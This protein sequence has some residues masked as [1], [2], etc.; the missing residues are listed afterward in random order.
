MKFAWFVADGAKCFSQIPFGHIERPTDGSEQVCGDW[1]CITGGDHGLTVSNDCKHSF[2]AKGNE[3]LLT[4]LRSALYADHFGKRDEFCEFMDQGEHTF[5]YRLAPFSGFANAERGAATLQ[6]PL[7]SYTETFHRGTLPLTASGLSLSAPNVVVTA[8][9]AHASG[10]GTIL[11]FLETEGRSAV[12]EGELFGTKFA[13]SLGH[14]AV[15]TLWIHGDT[16]EETDF[17]E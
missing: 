3:L 12:V 8:V 6:E 4:V 17:I 7:L 13:F 10:E 5:S 11:R 15:K 14:D 2:D 1:I 16:V 9:K